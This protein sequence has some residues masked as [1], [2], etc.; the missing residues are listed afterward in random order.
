MEKNVIYLVIPV[1]K[2]LHNLYIVR[3]VITILIWLALNVFI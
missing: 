2:H 3:N 1:Y